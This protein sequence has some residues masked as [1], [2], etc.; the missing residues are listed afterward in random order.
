MVSLVIERGTAT[1]LQE[2][3]ADYVR[4]GSIILKPVLENSEEL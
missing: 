2:P 1:F 3:V 4:I